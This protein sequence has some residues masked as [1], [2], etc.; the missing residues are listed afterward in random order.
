MD[1]KE[2][3]LIRQYWKTMKQIYNIISKYSY[4][5]CNSE[6]ISYEDESECH[7][8]TNNDIDNRINKNQ[9]YHK[10]SDDAKEIIFSILYE[11][12]KISSMRNTGESYNTK[13]KRQKITI[14]RLKRYF[15]NKW[16]GQIDV[17][18]RVNNAVLEVENFIKETNENRSY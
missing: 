13:W 4:N 18:N 1:N 17:R 5:P 6:F 14:E 12:K 10:L 3:E 9:L 8:Y 7:N 16:E 2:D 15:R 11:D